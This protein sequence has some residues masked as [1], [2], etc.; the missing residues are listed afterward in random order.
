MITIVS[1]PFVINGAATIYNRDHKTT[2]PVASDTRRT[3]EMA[4]TSQREPAE[5]VLQRMGVSRGP[6]LCLQIL[7]SPLN[8]SDTATSQ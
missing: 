2:I 3:T 8:I 4:M 1:I 5:C 6:L 7:E